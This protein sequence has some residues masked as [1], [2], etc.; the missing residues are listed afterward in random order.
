M[1]VLIVNSGSS[2]LKY[3]LFDMKN[4]SMLVKGQVERI[5]SD[6]AIITQHRDGQEDAKY[7][8][9]VWHHSEAVHCMLNVLLDKEH[10]VL[11]HVGE[12]EAVGHRIVHGGEWFHDA[13]LIDGEVQRKIKQLYDLAP[14]HNPAHMTG[15]QAVCEHLPGVPQVAVFDTAFHQTLPMKAYLYAIPFSLYKKY[16]IRRYGFHGTSHEYV[17]SRAAQLLGKPIQSIKMVTCHLGNGASCAAI[18]DGRSIDT[19]M[20]MTPLEGLMMGT[21]SGDMDCAIIPFLMAKE[22]LTIHEINSMLNKHSGLLAVSG[23]S[24]DVR[25]L[26]QA[27]EAGDAQA[28]L[29]L[30]MYE[31]R[32]RKYIGAYAA[33]MNG[34]DALVFTGGVGENS[35]FLRKKLCEQLTF[36]GIALNE[37]QNNTHS[38]KEK[39]ISTA[40][41]K[42]SVLVVPTNEE[43]LIA[44]KT[45][46]LFREAITV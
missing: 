33:A 38:P 17:S 24:G 36:L 4:E 9:P 23:I 41:S 14:L 29:A 43:L 11:E 46:S 12:I 1:K 37:E 2:S 45:F 44:Q 34:I 7:V 25:E 16:G 21:R 5:G 30:D 42:V 10:G 3:Q 40:A 28:N 13:T 27:A 19:S 18:A 26:L 35:A 32:I 6:T 20:G 31:Y 15:I 8:Q 22:D 39:I